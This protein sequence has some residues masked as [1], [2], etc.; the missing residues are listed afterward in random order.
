MKRNLTATAVS[1]LF[2]AMSLFGLAQAAAPPAALAAQPV[3]PGPRSTAAFAS[4]SERV[5]SLPIV[6]NY[7]GACDIT[8]TTAL[9]SGKVI[10]RGCPPHPVDATPATVHIFWGS[11]DGGKFAT[12]W[13]HDVNLGIQPGSVFSAYVAGLTPTTAYYYRSYMRNSAGAVW[14]SY[15][16]PFTTKDLED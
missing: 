13:E 15:S 16:Q 12:S 1:V 2:A 6:S 4:D 3:L 14:A 5:T 9:L 11:T 10:S 8:A 7:D